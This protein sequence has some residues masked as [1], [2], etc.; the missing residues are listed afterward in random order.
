MRIVGFP[1][2][3]IAPTI[4]LDAKG[5]LPPHNSDTTPSWAVLVVGDKEC[6]VAFTTKDA[7]AE[8]IKRSCL[9]GYCV[10]GLSRSDLARELRGLDKRV[11][12]AVLDPSLDGPCLNRMPL[13]RILA[14]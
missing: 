5:F 1:V 7:A 3:L 9:Q 2:Y 8:F 13:S 4:Q 6:L 11:E 14:S 10:H 12:M